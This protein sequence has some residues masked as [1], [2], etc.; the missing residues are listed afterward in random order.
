ME[1][2]QTPS[3]YPPH[4]LP[5]AYVYTGEHLCLKPLRK[6][7]VKNRYFKALDQERSPLCFL[8]FSPPLTLD[9]LHA[10][11]RLSL[12]AVLE[13][14][15]C[16][17]AEYKTHTDLLPPALGQARLQGKRR[18]WCGRVTRK[19]VGLSGVAFQNRR[20]VDLLQQGRLGG[21]AVL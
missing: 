14:S 6:M 9:G 12:T 2:P 5:S 3:A 1:R 10:S 7:Q 21:R 8:L 13:Q 4:K 19:A 17:G 16:Y 18:S 11:A 15:W 20:R